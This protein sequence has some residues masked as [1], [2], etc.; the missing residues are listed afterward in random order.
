M[1][2]EVL[3]VTGLAALPLSPLPSDRHAE[4]RDRVVALDMGATTETIELA[5]AAPGAGGPPPMSGPRGA[6]PDGRGMP[7]GGPMFG[8][9]L[10]EAQQD[11][12]FNLHHAQAPQM[13][14]QM[15]ALRKSQQALRDLARS[16]TFDEQRAQQIAAEI[17]RT[18]ATIALMRARL[19]AAVWKILTP[20]QRQRAAQMPM[21]RGPM[22][23]MGPMGGMHGMGGMGE[24][25]GPGPR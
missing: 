6:G 2:A 23:P 22:G 10:P 1:F 9:N 24:G 11:Q 12:I 16:D 5:Q 3:L 17:G 21:H 14:E 15:K 20:E 8:L 19:Q 25:F 4:M 7:G 13:R 18:E